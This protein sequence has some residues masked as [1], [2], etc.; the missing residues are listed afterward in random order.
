METTRVKRENNLL[1]L[2]PGNIIAKGLARTVYRHPDNSDLCIKIDH[3]EYRKNHK[4]MQREAAY[5]RRIMFFRRTREFSS[6]PK[7][8]GLVNTNLGTGA[9]FDLI[10]DEATGVISRPLDGIAI[11]E[12][13]R[14][15]DEL[16]AA[17]DKLIKSLFD[18]GIVLCDPH[19]GNIVVQELENAPP[20]LLFIDGIGHNNFIPIVDASIYLSRKKL[21]RV[22]TRER[23][24]RTIKLLAASKLAGINQHTYS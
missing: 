6:I 16:S 8:Y 22:L 3:Y 21:A 19:P 4:D 18:E 23:Y 20:R 11:D 17:L 2:A 10:K 15:H 9:I 1:I 7:F 5:Y 24:S 14:R 13:S 12:L